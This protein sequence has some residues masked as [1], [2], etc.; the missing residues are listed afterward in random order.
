MIKIWIL[1]M[2][3]MT[4]GTLLKLTVIFVIADGDAVDDDEDV[5]TPFWMSLSLT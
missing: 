3:M 1:M 5:Y 2:T 4:L